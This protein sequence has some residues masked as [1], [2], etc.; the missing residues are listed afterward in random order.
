[1]IPADQLIE[2]GRFGKPHGIKGEMSAVIPDADIDPADLPCM[3]VE[4]DG[5]MVPFFISSTR[6]KGSES[7]LITFEG[8][9]SQEKAARF[10]NKIIYARPCDLPETEEDGEGFYLDDLTGFDIVCGG[11]IIGE[12]TDFDDSTEN[13]LFVVSTSSGQEIL[14]PANPDLIEA[15]DTDTKTINM[16]LPSGLTDL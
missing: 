4:I 5:L 6:T 13:Y 14:I 10:T 16:N 9:D 3:F 2:I 12:I 1:M 8:V 15:I 7:V 11:A